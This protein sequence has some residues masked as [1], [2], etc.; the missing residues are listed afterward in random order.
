MTSA[1]A[2]V[3]YPSYCFHLSPT[4]NRW[5]PLRATDIVG[6]QSRPE[7]EVQDVFFHLNHPIRWVRVTGVVVAIDEYYGRRVYT[8]D[9][10]TGAC[11]ECCVTVPVPAKTKPLWAISNEASSDAAKT[12]AAD[13]SAEAP[14]QVLPDVDVG[15][16]VEFRGSV[17]TFRG[18]KQIKV[19]K[20]I[21]IRST[22]QEVQFW[23]KIRDFR[24]DFLSRPWLLER[25]EVRRCQKLANSEGDAQEKKHSKKK[26]KDKGNKD[27]LG[28][29]Q[30]ARR[31]ANS[32]DGVPVKPAKAERSS[33][34]KTMAVRT[35]VEGQ[36]DALGL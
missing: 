26:R 11:I 22:S 13:G 3:F 31:I 15:M 23:N 27:A 8:I 20:T 1:D 34:S 21:P 2:L 12:P 32:Q 10:S 9:D 28:E 4:I 25:K 19:L 35:Y 29:S 36:Y 24:R 18:Q 7:F 6:L 17:N 14:A 16:V 5:C 30:V 33:S